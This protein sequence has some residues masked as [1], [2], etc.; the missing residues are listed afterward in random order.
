MPST[1]SKALEVSALVA[2]M[3]GSVA[4][5]CGRL[6]LCEGVHVPTDRHRGAALGSLHL[7]LLGRCRL[8]AC[9]YAVFRERLQRSLGREL[10][11]VVEGENGGFV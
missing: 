3:P 8:D 2:H 5:Y 9:W 1:A 10:G 4:I 7:G 11:V 6:L